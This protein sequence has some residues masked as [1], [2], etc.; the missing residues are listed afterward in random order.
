M[1]QQEEE[2]LEGGLRVGKGVVLVDNL[3]RCGEEGRGVALPHVLGKVE[4]EEAS[5]HVHIGRVDAQ[6]GRVEDDEIR[7]PCDAHGLWI[8]ARVDPKVRMVPDQK[9]H[10]SSQPIL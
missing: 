9:G 7:E 5:C 3:V 1:D 10:P 4:V 6:I 8:C 2:G